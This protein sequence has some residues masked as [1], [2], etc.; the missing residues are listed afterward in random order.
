M[1]ENQNSYIV[2]VPGCHPVKRLVLTRKR[3]I[4]VDIIMW[5]GEGILLSNG[6]FEDKLLSSSP[7]LC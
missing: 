7:V 3:M 6:G 5:T 1:H 4:K 2:A